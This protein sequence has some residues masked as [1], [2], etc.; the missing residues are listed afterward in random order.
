MTCSSETSHRRPCAAASW[1]T[2][3]IMGSRKTVDFL[4]PSRRSQRRLR[5]AVTKPRVPRLPS[6]VARR[7]DTQ[8]FE[9]I[10]VVRSAL[11]R[12]P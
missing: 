8:P 4:R 2:A 5:A 6:S 9:Q 12:A 10:D 3:R 7:L 1:A 11:F